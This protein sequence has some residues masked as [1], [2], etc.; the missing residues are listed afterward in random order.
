LVKFFWHFKDAY[1]K[2]TTVNLQQL[3]HRLFLFGL[4]A[5]Y[6]LGWEIVTIAFW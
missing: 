2:A 3:S 5:Q 4:Q 6:L 1:S